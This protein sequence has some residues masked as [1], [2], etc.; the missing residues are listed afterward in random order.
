LSIFSLQASKNII[1]L[2]AEPKIQH[3]LNNIPIKENLED[4]PIYQPGCLRKV[5][6]IYCIMLLSH[7]Q[8]ICNFSNE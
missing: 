5:S 1:E 6:E 2:A 8:G 7:L 3:F 4:K